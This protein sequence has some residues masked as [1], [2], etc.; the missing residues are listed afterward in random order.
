[1]WAPGT[2]PRVRRGGGPSDDSPDGHVAAQC[3][4]ASGAAIDQ[5]IRVCG[6]CEA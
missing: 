6:D 5:S 3:P 2:P 4:R 1:M